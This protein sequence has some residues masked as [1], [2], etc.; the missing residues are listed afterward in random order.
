MAI[1]VPAWDEADVIADMLR[2]SLRR[3]DY[4]SYRLFV[5]VYPN[6]PQTRLAVATVAD[7][8]VEMVV[9]T[10]PGPTSKADCLNHLYHAALRH[11]ARAGVPV[12]AFVLH[13]AED[14]VDPQELTVFNHLIPRK[15][16]VQAPVIALP[17]PGSR[18]VAGS[19]MDEF[20]EC[21]A[22][23]MVVREWLGRAAERGRRLRLQR[24]HP[25]AA[26][27]RERRRAVQRDQRHRGLR[28]RGAHR[29]ARRQGG[30]GAYSGPAW[31]HRHPGAL[32]AYRRRRDPPACA[33]AAWHRAHGLGSAG[34]AG[35]ARGSLHALA[36][37]QGAAQCG[38]DRRRLF[39]PRT[40]RRACHGAG[41]QPGASGHPWFRPTR[42]CVGVAHGHQ[43][44]PAR[45]AAGVAL[46]L[47]HAAV[48][49]A[50]GPARDTAHTGQQFHQRAGR[51]PRG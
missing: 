41:A 4:P 14:L 49:L 51:L 38:P 22:K 6:D 1:L 3:L 33:L 36:R 29:S 7:P 25:G 26:R 17:D 9:T 43:W 37:S 12:K 30:A 23:D 50:R 32:P 18:W 39:R 10:R 11:A 47:R 40:H 42:Q 48:R 44:R 20:A 35:H 34:L 31:R 15:A 21:H 27:V 13:D 2:A 45:L 5:G 19:Y 46:G 8:R 24:R 28:T 16:M